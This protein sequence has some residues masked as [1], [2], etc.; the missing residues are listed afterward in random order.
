MLSELLEKRWGK[1]LT[2]NCRQNENLQN[3]EEA[4]DMKLETV[5]RKNFK[6]TESLLRSLATG[7]YLVQMRLY[8]IIQGKGVSV[9]LFE[10]P[11]LHCWSF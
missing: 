11:S 9:G 5:R 2:E 10:L 4:I 6:L 1:I 3:N 8:V 7:T